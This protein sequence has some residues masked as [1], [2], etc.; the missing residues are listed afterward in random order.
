MCLL[1]RFWYCGSR[2]NYCSS[3]LPAVQEQGPTCLTRKKSLARLQIIESWMNTGTHLSNEFQSS[4]K[5]A[6]I[7]SVVG[8]RDAVFSLLVE[9]LQARVREFSSSAK[10]YGLHNLL[11]EG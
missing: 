5:V 7:R 2:E 10:R 6:S 11:Y 1:L 9:R 8:S 4:S 3:E